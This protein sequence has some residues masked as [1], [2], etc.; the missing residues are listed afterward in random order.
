[1]EEETILGKPEELTIWGQEW[2]G[3]PEFH[4]EELRP[5][6]SV[7]VHFA[8][9]GDMEEF[10]KLIEQKLTAKTRSLWFPKAEIE[11]Y[12]NKRYSDES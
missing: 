7:I 5:W 8:G 3:M 2:Q 4:Q 9:P 6:K 10:A 11:R 1:M 12:V